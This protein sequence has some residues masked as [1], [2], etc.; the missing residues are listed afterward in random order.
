[1]VSQGGTVSSR[2]AKHSEAADVPWRKSVLVSLC[3]ATHCR[4]ANALQTRLEAAAVSC[5][6]FSSVYT[7]MISCSSEVMTPKPNPYQ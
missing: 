1:M 3:D 2:R 7:E 6:G 5:E 4:S